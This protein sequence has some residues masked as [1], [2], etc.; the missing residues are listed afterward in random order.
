MVYIF[1]PL[2]P[3]LSPGERG[4]RPPSLGHT[5]DGVC[6]TSVRKTSAW[7]G[8]FHPH[9]PTTDLR[10]YFLSPRGTSGERTEER[11]VQSERA[12]SPQPSPPSCVRRRGRKPRSQ[13]Q[14]V[15]ARKILTNSD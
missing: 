8:L 9:E 5:R 15:K 6:Q 4:N 14:G 13:V 2:T 10:R 1:Y 7:R 11:G 3:A 12:S